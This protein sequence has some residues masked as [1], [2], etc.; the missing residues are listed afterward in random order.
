M[1][2][3]TI[4]PEDNEGQT[5]YTTE[6][7]YEMNCAELA[8]VKAELVI[9]EALNVMQKR[10][11]RKMLTGNQ[12]V[13]STKDLDIEG[14]PEHVEFYLDGDELDMREAQ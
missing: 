4:Y 10:A 14:A 1:S 8:A 6:Q 9:L 12:P 2:S 11:I 7:M 3:S 5:V 13:V